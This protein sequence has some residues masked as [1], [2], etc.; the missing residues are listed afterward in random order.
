MR[1]LERLEAGAFDSEPDGFAR[2]FVRAVALAIG[3]D[4]DETVARML[5][6]PAI[7]SGVSLSGLGRS[8]IVL[9]AVLAAAVAL[10][11]VWATWQG[12]APV[13]P[14]E[15]PRA[16]LPVRR[17]AVRALALEVGATEREVPSPLE[18]ASEAGLGPPAE[19]VER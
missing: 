13:A 10:G 19:T 4:A 18:P 16:E 1:S 2:G 9:G 15:E 5:E 6:E 7:E 8:L 17:D 12:A 11:V 14:A 3:L